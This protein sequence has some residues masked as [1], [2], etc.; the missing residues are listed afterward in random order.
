MRVVVRACTGPSVPP[1]SSARDPISRTVSPED[2]QV[3][4]PA[5]GALVAGRLA[6]NLLIRFPYV[7][8]TSISRGLGL[9][10]G[11]TTALLGVRE[12]GGL[13]APGIGHLADRGHQRRAMALC[14]GIAGL[15]TIA[16][17]IA[18]PVGVVAALLTLGGVAKFGLDTAQ[19]TWIGQR[20]PFARRARVFGLVELSW[21]GAFFIGIP[22]CAAVESRWGWRGLFVFSG[23]LLCLTAAAM[24]LW[25]AEDGAHGL[26]HHRRPRLTRANAGMFAYAFCQPFAQMFVFAVVGDWFVDGLGMTNVALGAATVLIGVGEV[27]GTGTTAVITDRIGKRRAAL[28][29]MAIAAPATVGLGLVG[30]APWLGVGMVVILAAGI[31][32]SFV[33]ALPILSELDPEARGASIGLATAVITVSRAASS[34]VAGVTYTWGGITATGLVGGLSAAGAIAGLLATSEP[35]TVNRTDR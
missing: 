23:G 5:L 21:A 3:S 1:M 24:T 35:V 9:S 34:A 25:V 4:R 12:L 22:I 20:V 31:E 28:I 10:V 33:S 13:A 11:A 19:A 17:A 30:R 2:E 15:S 29:G 14:A 18:P 7:F 27:V 8:L 6:G 26:R 32:F 16:I